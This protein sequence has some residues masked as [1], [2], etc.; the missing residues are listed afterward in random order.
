[1]IRTLL[2]GLGTRGRHWA[3][4]IAENAGSSLVAGVDPSAEAMQTL[5]EKLPNLEFVHLTDRKSVV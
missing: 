5:Q 3:R 4:V 2:V 1:M